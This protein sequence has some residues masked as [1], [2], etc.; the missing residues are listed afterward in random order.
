MS[1]IKKNNFYLPQENINFG[2]AT[3]RALRSR[4]RK[5]SSKVA[6]PLIQTKSK[7]SK[8]ALPKVAAPTLSTSPKGKKPSKKVVAN[9]KVV[10]Q[11]SIIWRLRVKPTPKLLQYD[12]VTSY[13]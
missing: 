10:S 12:I 7:R 5:F 9:K 4:T 1:V 8:K 6:K 2:V 11:K 3:A 13:S